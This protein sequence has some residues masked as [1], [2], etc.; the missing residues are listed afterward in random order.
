MVVKP[1]Q[2]SVAYLVVRRHSKYRPIRKVARH[3][4]LDQMMREHADPIGRVEFN[5]VSDTLMDIEVVTRSGSELQPM[6]TRTRPARCQKFGSVQ[7][8]KTMIGV[9]RAC[10][11][12]RPRDIDHWKEILHDTQ[13]TC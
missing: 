8:I 4:L 2:L 7:A 11:V 9:R 12:R 13:F 6:A 5:I 3:R 1:T 10:Y